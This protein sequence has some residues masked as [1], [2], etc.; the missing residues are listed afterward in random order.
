M[1]V[2]P[3]FLEHVL[4]LFAG[5]GP[6][7]QGRMFSGV[8]LYA[9]GDAM[10]AMIAAS[11]TVYMKADPQTEPRFLDAG[12]DCFWYMRADRRQEVRSLYSLPESALD[13]PDEALAWA[14][15]ALPPAQAAAAEKRRARARRKTRS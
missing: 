4:D 7:R 3:D 5:M 10:F 13:D 1:P 15:L 6:L 9:E 14:R 2:D 11:G 12:S 8:A